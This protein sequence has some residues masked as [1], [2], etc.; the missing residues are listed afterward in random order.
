[1]IGRDPAFRQ[2]ARNTAWFTVLIVPVQCG[3]ALLLAVWTN[4]RGWSRR[5]LRIAVFVPTT[6]SLTVLAVL[7][8]LMYEPAG[9][10]GAGLIN[11][12][13]V[14]LGLPDQPFLTS[15]SQALLCIAAMS[16]W[17]GVGFQ[18]MIFLAGLQT[19]PRDLYEAAA[20]DGARSPQ[21]FRHITLPGIAPT[22]VLV[23]MI[24]TIFALKLFVQPYLMT[25]G[26]P[27][28]AT[29]SVVQYVY[30]VFREHELGLACAAGAVFFIVVTVV[31]A[32]Q[33]RLLRAYP[34]AE[35]RA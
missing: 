25:K 6:I 14:A 18:M 1:V 15:R 26:G 11:G 21:R 31:A 4:G 23:V 27:Q 19:I 30:E 12:L 7:W 3:L 5:V 34:T 9:A 24:T 29:R 16:V 20:I 10:T 22:L 8:K 13:L 17:Q 35:V 32:V 28:G 33:R 2:A